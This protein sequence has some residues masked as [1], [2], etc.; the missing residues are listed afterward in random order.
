[1]Q[2]KA[3]KKPLSSLQTGLVTCG[4]WLGQRRE[5]QFVATV[6]QYSCGKWMTIANLQMNYIALIYHDLPIKNGDFP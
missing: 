3:F 1:L 4:E 2:A 5:D 6:W